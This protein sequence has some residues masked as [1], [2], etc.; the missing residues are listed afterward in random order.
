VAGPVP[1]AR[2]ASR[3]GRATSEA[4]GPRDR[5][6]SPETATY[7]DPLDTR[8][9]G[10]KGPE[11][12]PGEQSPQGN[13]GERGRLPSPRGLVGATGTRGPI[14]HADPETK[15]KAA[16]LQQEVAELRDHIA[17]LGRR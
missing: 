10:P 12:E 9:L 2:L 16:Q 6:A 1:T 7:L 4:K 13:A 17:A 15:A 14:G 8:P 11:G 3:S 5:R